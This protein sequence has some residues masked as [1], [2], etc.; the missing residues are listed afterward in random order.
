MS[1]Q[2]GQG[3]PRDEERPPAVPPSL[4]LWVHAAWACGPG[5]G[6]RGKLAGVCSLAGVHGRTFRGRGRSQS[7]PLWGPQ[8]LFSVAFWS[9]GR[10]LAGAERGLCTPCRE[11]LRGKVH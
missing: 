2:A 10:G 4:G 9:R 3:D 5:G 1:E 6:C 7:W 8:S 11:E